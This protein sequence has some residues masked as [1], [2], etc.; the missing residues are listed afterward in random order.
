LSGIWISIDDNNGVY[1]FQQPCAFDGRR[2]IGVKTICAGTRVLFEA[3]PT[4]GGSTPT[5]QWY[6]NG[7]AI[8]GAIASTYTYAPANGDVV[9]IVITSNASCAS[10]STATSHIIVIAHPV[11]TVNLSASPSSVC[12]GGSSTLTANVTSGSTT[13]MTYTWYIAGATYT[14]NSNTYSLSNLNATA[15]YSVKVTNSNG[16]EESATVTV[17]V[18]PTVVPSISIKA[19]T[20][21]VCAN[22]AVTFSPLSVSGE[23][24]SPTYDW[25]VNGSLVGS[26]TSYTYAPANNDVVTCKLTSSETCANPNPAT[27]SGITMTITPIVI[28]SLTITAVP[29]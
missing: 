14:T 15:N 20:N 11:P 2:E 16:C 25:Y 26:G 1:P 21:N 12:A 17:S 8:G 9:S 27:S 5:Y 19:S 23:G 18:T 7:T 22:T 29:D 28:P 6:K 10:P 4:E 24:S 3:H 13:A